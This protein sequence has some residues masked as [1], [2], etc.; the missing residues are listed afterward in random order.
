MAAGIGLAIL[1]IVAYPPA[2]AA[3]ETPPVYDGSGPATTAFSPNVRVNSGNP[4]YA[5]QVEPT[6]AVNSQGRV[7]VGWKEALTHNGG[8]QRVSFSDSADGGATWAPNVMMNLHTYARQSDPWLTVTA[9]DRVYFG[10][11]EYDSPSSPGGITFTNTTD[12]VAWGTD[13]LLSDAPNFADKQTH[14]HD[15]AG[16]VYVAWN[17]DA[18]PATYDV[19][20]SRSNDGGATWTPKVRVPDT[21]NGALGA[22]VQVS[23]N[24]QVNIAWWSWIS[25]NL[26]FDRS[27]DGGVTWGTDVRVN[28]LPGSAESPLPS[29]PPILPAMAVAA[30]GTIYVVWNDYRNGRPAGTAN[31][32]FDI[33]FSRSADG[34]ATW[35]PSLR[36]NDDGTTARQWMPDLALDP[37]GGVH[38]AWMDDRNGGHDVYYA[39]ST[40]GGTTW[41]PNVRV[42]TVSTPLSF[43]RPGDYLALESDTNGNIY[44]AWT[45]GRGTDLDIYVSRLERT[46]RYTIDTVPAGLDVQV[47]GATYPAPH[48][49]ACPSGTFRA[50]GAPS[51]QGSG[52]TRHLFVGWSD[53]GAQTHGLPCGV[54]GTYTAFFSTE[55][56]ITMMT[57]PAG[58]VF[59]GDGASLVGPQSF[60]W[61]E[62]SSHAVGAPSPQGGGETRYLFD[63]WSDGGAPTHTINVTEPSTLVAE[64]RTQYRLAVTS[65]H[66][67]VGCDVSDCWYDA[68]ST[69]TFTVYPNL[70]D[71]APG[72]RY[73]FRTW[74]SDATGTSP[75]GNA[76]MDRP[77][78]AVALWATEHRLSIVSAYG[79]PVGAGWH[80]EG[81]PV[82]V[83]VEETIV[84]NG[85]TYRFV[86]WTGDAI[87]PD[88]AI[89]VTMDAPK[90]LTAIWEE[91]RPPPENS[92]SLPV[93]VLLLLVVFL[94]LVFFLWRRRKQDRSPVPPPS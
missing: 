33:L 27:L 30:N 58:L 62:G 87:S 65:A 76:T 73:V 5:Y 64:F 49:F 17:S 57:S 42:T 20:F 72:T 46:A 32:N 15:A 74:S 40:D 6:M 54:S 90:T 38:A 59:T 26:L 39:N 28:D 10:R 50:I 84:V 22:F 45:D 13:L 88:A 1:A 60:W 44:A 92:S 35:S 9:S 79:S 43:N 91:V 93:W 29:D 77:R 61:G 71:G 94:I 55:H 19:V 80:E 68:G 81:L 67:S 11:I 7:F 24:G 25:D 37:F 70:M 8:G 53:G 12:G 34:G 23:P 86:G 82:S 4:S 48:A 56:E 36:L 31:G 47:D 85:T 18:V 69:A 21:T 16:N 51:P 52:G 3:P 83:E 75:T 66:G 78:T 89:D 14:A 63:R 2:S 41:G